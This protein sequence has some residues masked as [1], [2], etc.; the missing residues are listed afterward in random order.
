MAKGSSV[1][2]QPREHGV[3]VLLELMSKGCVTAEFHSLGLEV[4]VSDAAESA[5]L[6]DAFRSS[7][8]GL[9]AFVVLPVRGEHALSD[10]AVRLS[11][12]NFRVLCDLTVP[13]EKHP[14]TPRNTAVLHAAQFPLG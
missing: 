3:D 14:A 8:F 1:M 9:L 5:A 6:R 2:Y 13:I 11:K 12:W 10:C 4:T 7:D